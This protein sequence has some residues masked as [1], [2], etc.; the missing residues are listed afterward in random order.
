[1][2][3]NGKGV[4]RALART[5]VHPVAYEILR[6]LS[7]RDRASGKE[8]A[9]A[10]SKPR[11]TVGDQLRRLQADDLIESVAE[12][13]RRGT[14]ERF[15]RPAP[16]ARWVD[17]EEMALIDAD[18][19]RRIGLRVVRSALVDAMAALSTN[20]L[21]RRDDWCLSGTRV[22]V[23]ARGW[24]EL[25]D[26]YRRTVEEV[27]RVR[28]ESAERLAATDAEPLR[29]LSSLFLLELPSQD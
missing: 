13:T 24:S 23:D 15:Y 26:I 1:M 9:E 16:A 29:A 28:E 5:L 12:E 7:E 18:E 21:E 14:V 20:T 25:A 10:L 8:L 4:N 2:T 27:E 3:S 22:S 17:E 11:S 19:R 6:L